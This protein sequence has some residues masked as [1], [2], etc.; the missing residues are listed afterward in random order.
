MLVRFVATV[1]F[2]K[3][4]TISCGGAGVYFWHCIYS[5]VDCLLS[6]SYILLYSIHS[7]SFVTVFIYILL[8][9]EFWLVSVSAFEIF[10]YFILLLRK[11]QFGFGFVSLL[12]FYCA[13]FCRGL[14]CLCVRLGGSK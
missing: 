4:L 7:P 8:F 12:I 14:Q 11:C 13:F 6:V 10:S 9:L 2:V 5:V 3:D 1:L